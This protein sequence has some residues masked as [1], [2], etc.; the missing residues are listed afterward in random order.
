VS[1]S[2]S[3]VLN[4]HYFIY[5]AIFLSN[6]KTSYLINASLLYSSNFIENGSCEQLSAYS[7][8]S[9]VDDLA[10]GLMLYVLSAK[11]I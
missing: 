9:S 11:K 3:V 8:G 5:A 6:H 1:V 4:L 2:M 10:S 7:L